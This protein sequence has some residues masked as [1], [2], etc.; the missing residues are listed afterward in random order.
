MTGAVV[1]VDLPAAALLD[2][3]VRVGALVR[4]LAAKVKTK[5]DD[6]LRLVSGLS[7]YMWRHHR[8]AILRH[9]DI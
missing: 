4:I 6:A 5:D 2:D 1:K 7:G 8:E 3:P 9:L